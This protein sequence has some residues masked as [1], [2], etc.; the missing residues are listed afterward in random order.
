MNKAPLPV[1]TRQDLFI[2]QGLQ[3]ALS[4][5]KAYVKVNFKKLNK[6]KSPFF[7]PWEN[8]LPLMAIL[9]LSIF[10][11]IADN[12]IIGM[13]VLMVS[14][15]AYAFLMPYFLEPFMQNR[16]TKR[17]VP[18]IEKFL[19]AWRY[20]GITLVVTADPR[21]SCQAP[22]GNWQQFTEMY[23]GDLIPQDMAEKE[24]EKNA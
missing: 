15:I 19:V 9:V 21:F 14:C 8:I 13:A 4:E 24:R 1:P 20:G 23:F 3:R 7:N 11:M 6:F 5:K 10:L 16:V 12:L 2:F 18:R 22:L 17:I